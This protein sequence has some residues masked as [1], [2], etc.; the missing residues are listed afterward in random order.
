MKKLFQPKLINKFIFLNKYHKILKV[1][2][3]SGA[4]FIGSHLSSFLIK[5]K[6]DNS[7]IKNYVDDA[8][9]SVDD[10]GYINLWNLYNL[11]T[12]SSKSNY[13]DNFLSRNC[14]TYEFVNHLGLSI[15]NQE[16]NYFLQNHEI[17]H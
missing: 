16:A 3:T 12:E 8:Y 15:K 14:N 2:I 11:F 17:V 4:G 7:I 9:F 13:I 1:L 6:H 10:D 5:E